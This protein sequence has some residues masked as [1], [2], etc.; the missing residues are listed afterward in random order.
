MT[1]T[2][3][4]TEA[5]ISYYKAKGWHCVAQPTAGS[6]RIV[7][8]HHYDG[9]RRLMVTDTNGV[10][11]TEAQFDNSDLGVVLF[12]NVVALAVEMTA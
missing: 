6:D 5:T 2:T 7:F 1:T 11:Y 12:D 9:E 8:T 4:H 3:D 10:I